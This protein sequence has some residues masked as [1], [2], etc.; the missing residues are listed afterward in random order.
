METGTAIVDPN[1][2]AE[3]LILAMGY[4]SRT[5]NQILEEIGQTRQQSGHPGRMR[6]ARD[7]NHGTKSFSH[8]R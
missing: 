6:S 4:T 3:L 2:T 7:T 8:H 1:V 5:A